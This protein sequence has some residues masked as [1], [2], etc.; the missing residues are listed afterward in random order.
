MC[1]GTDVGDTGYNGL[2][3]LS[4][5]V[6]GNHVTGF[7][8]AGQRRSIPACAGEP[9]SRQYNPQGGEVYPRV[10]GGTGG[11]AAAN[12]SPVGLSPR[13]RGNPIGCRMRTPGLRSIPACAGEPGFHDL[14]VPVAEVYPRVCGGTHTAPSGLTTS[15]GLSPRVRGNRILGK[16][17]PI[18]PR[19]IPAC[20]GEPRASRKHE[21]GGKVYPRV[22]GGTPS[23]T[24][25][26]TGTNG[27]SPRVRG[28]PT[29]KTQAALSARSIPACAGEPSLTDADRA[30]FKVYPRVCGG[31]AS[32]VSSAMRWP[33]LSPRVRGNPGGAVQEMEIKRSIPA[34]AGEPP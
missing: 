33:G 2:A 34:C 16:R 29:Y 27:L 13:V 15:M 23:T 19:S 17:R 4:P 20:A 26:P 8:F 21:K 24:S 32:G 5:R 10:C 7:G 9:D 11:V 18:I 30:E 25:L 1:G 14:A 12:L 3:G 22:C 28:N 31:T 6:R